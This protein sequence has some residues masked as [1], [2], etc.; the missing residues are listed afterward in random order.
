MKLTTEQKA[1]LIFKSEV[2][3]RRNQK[4]FLKD[5]GGDGSADELDE[6]LAVAMKSKPAR[7]LASK[8]KREREIQ[9]KTVSAGVDGRVAE[10][11]AAIQVRMK[12]QGITQSDLAGTCG[13]SQPLVSDY[14]SGR[15]E[16]GIGNLCKIVE[17]IG[18]CLR[19]EVG[20]QR[21]LK[22]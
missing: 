14:L 6:V 8:L 21:N 11:L 12:D 5:L 15:K 22:P 17:A 7:E 18:C 16:P 3:P 4:R 13:W 20:S 10:L 19:L 1:K 9:V 2:E